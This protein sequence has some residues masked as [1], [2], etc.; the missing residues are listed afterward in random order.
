MVLHDALDPRIAEDDPE[1]CDAVVE[2]VEAGVESPD[3]TFVIVVAAANLIGHC[4]AGGQGDA[5]IELALATIRQIA[6]RVLVAKT[7]GGRA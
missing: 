2:L 7:G 4:A 1:V 3:T 6:Q 5:D